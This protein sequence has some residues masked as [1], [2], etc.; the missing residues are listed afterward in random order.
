M[1]ERGQDVYVTL[2]YLA[3]Y[4][5]HSDIRS[6]EYYLKLLPSAHRDILERMAPTSRAIFGGDAL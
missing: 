5:G 3:A 6:T 4:M 1:V 2:P